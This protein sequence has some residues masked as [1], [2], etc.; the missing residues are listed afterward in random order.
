MVATAIS[1][2]VQGLSGVPVT[3]EVD[4]ANGLPIFQGEVGPPYAYRE[5]LGLPANTIA[6]DD[7]G[8]HPV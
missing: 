1:C 4:V 8:D 6:H 5:K 7:Q 2:A 3:V